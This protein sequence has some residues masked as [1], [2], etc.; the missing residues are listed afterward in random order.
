MSDGP[1]AGIRPEELPQAWRAEF[2]QL[3]Q[4]L[5]HLPKM[6]LEIEVRSRG[7]A[8]DSSDSMP[9]RLTLEVGGGR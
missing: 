6:M 1:V 8:Q 2:Q 5:A 7:E 9:V 3:R 4:A